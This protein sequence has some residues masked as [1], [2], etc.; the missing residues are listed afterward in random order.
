MRS[1]RRGLPIE[2]AATRVA[3][4]L[5]RRPSD[6]LWTQLRASRSLAALLDALRQSDCAVYVSGIAATDSLIDIELAF[7]QQLRGQI[8]ELAA[9]APDEW[10]AAVAFTGW[11]IDL[12]ALAHLA[13]AE[14]APAWTTTDRG[15]AIYAQPEPGARQRALMTGVPGALFARA[16][17]ATPTA[18]VHPLVAAWEAEWVGL[19]PHASHEQRAALVGLVA[20]VK[21]HLVAFRSGEPADSDT[22]RARLG[23]RMATALRLASAQPAALFAWLVVL[24]LDLERL[25]GLAIER[26]AFAESLR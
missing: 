18:G 1:T 4:R 9:I 12:P 23:V 15:L 5:A 3:A 26:A 16:A 11:L 6:R 2:Y 17:G 8:A 7:R 10:Q 22:A 14:A 19:W 24:A 21:Q 20:A 13:R 25:R